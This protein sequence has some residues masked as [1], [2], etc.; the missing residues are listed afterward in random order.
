M[1]PFWNSIKSFFFLL[2]LFCW[3]QPDV[4]SPR[5][6]VSHW[7]LQKVSHV[8][9]TNGK[10]NQDQSA[11]FSGGANRY[12]SRQR[13]KCWL[14]SVNTIWWR[15]KNKI[16]L[17]LIVCTW[18]LQIGIRAE[19]VTQPHLR[20]LEKWTKTKP[21]EKQEHRKVCVCVGV[22]VHSCLC[23]PTVRK[24]VRVKK[25]YTGSMRI[26]NQVFDEAYENSNSS[27]FKALAKQV[28]S[29][30][31]PR[32]SIWNE[33]H[34]PFW[35]FSRS[36]HW[37]C[38]SALVSHSLKSS[39]PRVH[40]WPSTMSAPLSRLS[41]EAGEK[42]IWHAKISKANELQLFSLT[43]AFPSFFPYLCSCVLSS[44]EGSVIAYY[45]SEFNVPT[46]QEA[47]VDNAMA[48]MSKLV[49]KEQ[50][51]LHRPGNSLMFEDVVSSGR[52][53]ATHVWFSP[54]GTIQLKLSVSVCVSPLTALDTRL[55]STSFSSKYLKT[56]WR[57][58]NV[59]ALQRWLIIVFSQWH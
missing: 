4:T 50:R 26:T 54:G 37:C 43:E 11:V 36:F 20:N 24:D 38:V 14:A 17:I 39:T 52:V 59:L 12:G 57:V 18:N 33:Q 7:C 22:C 47:A 42:L 53:R 1:F 3:I 28:T 13:E 27:E 32:F 6:S 40:S 58:W 55:L 16:H 35:P 23:D 44:S 2:W 29:Q 51:T 21:D 19:P 34:S 56:N 5:S 48:S 49:D 15:K 25:M 46:G 45:L 10:N 31:R 41:G 8:F 9:W 30:V